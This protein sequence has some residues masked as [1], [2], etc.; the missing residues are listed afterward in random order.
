MEVIL[1]QQSC[2]DAS[3]GEANILTFMSQKE[4]VDMIN[5]AKSVVILCH[6]DN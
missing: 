4:K 1:I 3:K 5:K 6:C 2:V